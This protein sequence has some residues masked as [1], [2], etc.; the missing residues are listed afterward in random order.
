MAIGAIV[1]VNTP[2]SVCRNEE[3]GDIELMEMP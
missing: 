2:S 3:E 1:T